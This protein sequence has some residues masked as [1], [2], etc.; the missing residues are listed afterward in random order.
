MY[1]LEIRQYQIVQTARNELTIIYVP[2]NR[3]SNIERILSRTLKKTLAQ[4][5][6][7]NDVIL[8]FKNVKSISRHKLSGKFNPFLS[9]GAPGD[10]DKS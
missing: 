9:L 4:R 2:Q 10:L 5:N 8:R 7:E 1:L 3:A 6:L